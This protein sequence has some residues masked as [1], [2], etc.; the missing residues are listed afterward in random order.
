MHVIAVLLI[1]F[2]NMFTI[3]YADELFIPANM[4]LSESYHGV[5]VRQDDSS[6][7]LVYLATDSDIVKLPEN[8]YIP[9]GK[10]H[11]SFDI[12]LY[13]TGD[14]TVIAQYGNAFFNSTVK[15]YNAVNSDYNILLVFP[16][17]TTV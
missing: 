14:A 5:F 13:G 12:S 4:I 3:A 17:K 6:S 2:A 10:N 7:A 11:A 1:A 15:I 9:A 8:V 16:Q